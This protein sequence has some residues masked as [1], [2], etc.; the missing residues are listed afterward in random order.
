MNSFNQEFFRIFDVRDKNYT[1]I[2]KN[3]SDS[4]KSSYVNLLNRAIA[5][6]DFQLAK[7]IKV[8]MDLASV[9]QKVEGI[10]ALNTGRLMIRGGRMWKT[11]YWNKVSI[12]K[13]DPLTL[14]MENWG[15]RWAR[16]WRL[17]GLFLIEEKDNHYRWK[18]IK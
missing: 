5:E 12:E 10:Y 2:L 7:E 17:E 9:L 11:S 18:K 14:R 6:K 3:V 8:K 16:T 1:R 4:F 15:P 13:F